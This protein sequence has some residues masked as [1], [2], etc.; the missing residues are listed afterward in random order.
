MI[1]DYCTI[2]VNRHTWSLMVTSMV[3]VPSLILTS[4]DQN[5]PSLASR[6]PSKV[7]I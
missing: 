7:A 6:R 2:T 1:N 3:A 5:L 4:K